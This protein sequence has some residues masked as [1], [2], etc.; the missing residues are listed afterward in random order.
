MEN[1]LLNRINELAKLSKERALTPQEVA[2]RDL[3]RKQYIAE[4]RAGA[5]Q[6]LQNTYVVTPDGQKHPLRKKSGSEE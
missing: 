2:E 4:W 1:S 6:V 3:L 5:E